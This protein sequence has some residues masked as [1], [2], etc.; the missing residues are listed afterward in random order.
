MKEIRNYVSIYRK[1]TQFGKY[2]YW[3]DGTMMTSLSITFF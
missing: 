3:M 2:A 1:N